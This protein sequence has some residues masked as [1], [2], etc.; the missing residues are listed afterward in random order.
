[1]YCIM[2]NYT[3]YCES[4]GEYNHILKYWYKLYLIWS[5]ESAD[6]S[7]ITSLSPFLVNDYN[8]YF[9][10]ISNFPPEMLYDKLFLYIYYIF[11]FVG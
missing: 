7:T 11:H 9:Q 5:C 1:M 3:A 4:S 10:S 8:Y 2:I 6:L